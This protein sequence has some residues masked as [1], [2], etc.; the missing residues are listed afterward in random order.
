MNFFSQKNSELHPESVVEL[1]YWSKKWGITI[2]QLNEAIVDTGSTNIDYLKSHL[3][4]NRIVQL[5]FLGWMRTVTD[6]ISSARL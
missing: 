1:Q 6:K 3:K 5:P 2:R 4:K